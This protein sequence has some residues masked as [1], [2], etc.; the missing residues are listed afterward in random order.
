M[1]KQ[2]NLLLSWFK[3]KNEAK[4]KKQPLSAENALCL[5]DSNDN[6]FSH[7]PTTLTELF[8]VYLDKVLE[9]IRID[10]RDT[11]YQIYYFKPWMSKKIK[12]ELTDALKHLGYIIKYQDDNLYIVSWKIED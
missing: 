2:F 11:T 9:Q 12:T 7:A 6:F 1:N 3:T 8:E 10:A 5:Y 4:V